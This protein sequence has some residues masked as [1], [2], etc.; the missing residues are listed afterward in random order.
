M[1]YIEF[2]YHCDHVGCD[3]H[4]YIPGDVIDSSEMLT[5]VPKS[6]P[7]GW[8][9]GNDGKIYCKEHSGWEQT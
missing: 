5:V 4:T 6:M 9:E 1:I 2:F 8:C 3:H 7:V